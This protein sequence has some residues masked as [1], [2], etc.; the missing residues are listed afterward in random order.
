MLSRQSPA[1]NTFLSDSCGKLD[2]LPVSLYLLEMELD[3]ILHHPLFPF[4]DFRTNDT[5]FLMLRRYWAAVA[6]EALGEET[7]VFVAPLQAADQ[8]KE[9]WGDPLML[10][11]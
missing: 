7:S 10:D 11:F 2:T 8:D 1:S 4:A 9:N 5:S 6:R 3:Q